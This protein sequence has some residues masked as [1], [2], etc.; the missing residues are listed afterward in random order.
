M[1]T[2]DKPRNGLAGLKH[3]R[4]G[5]GAGLQVA[6]ASLP[7]SL[8]IAVASRVPLLTGVISS[9]ALSGGL[10]LRYVPIVI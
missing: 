10:C 3:W 5:L 8:G 4:H 7:F 2:E 1:Q 9:G 6:L